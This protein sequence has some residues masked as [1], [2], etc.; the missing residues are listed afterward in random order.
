MQIAVPVPPGVGAPAKGLRPARRWPNSRE[1]STAFNLDLSVAEMRGCYDGMST[2]L[3]NTT[4]DLW[5]CIGSWYSGDW[6]GGGAQTYI[7][8]VQN[9]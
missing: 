6:H 8:W 3:G 4:G 9:P 1:R 7:G 5:G 2:Y